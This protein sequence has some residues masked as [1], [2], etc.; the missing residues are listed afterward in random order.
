MEILLFFI[1]LLEVTPNSTES[2]IDLCEWDFVEPEDRAELLIKCGV[3]HVVRKTETSNKGA[4]KSE[5]ALRND[6]WVS[7]EYMVRLWLPPP[8]KKYTDHGIREGGGDSGRESKWQLS[9]INVKVSNTKITVLPQRRWNFAVF[10][11][12]YNSSIVSNAL[13]EGKLLLPFTKQ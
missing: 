11:N 1:L 6:C 9:Y 8:A 10:W 7:V 2:V 4:Q 3:M 12:I 13:V 5:E